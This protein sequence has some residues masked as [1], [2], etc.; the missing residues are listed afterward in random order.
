MKHL[1]RSLQ[2]KKRLEELLNLK[3]AHK[4]E[5]DEDVK[6]ETQIRIEKE[7]D[8]L[9]KIDIETSDKVSIIKI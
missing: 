2:E 9:L 5:L 4:E 7:S 3:L 6:N 8:S 1:V